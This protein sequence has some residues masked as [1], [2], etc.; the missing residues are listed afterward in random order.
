MN[1]RNNFTEFDRSMG[2]SPMI[3]TGWGDGSMHSENNAINYATADLLE[4]DL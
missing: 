4:V 2:K 1:T 3:I